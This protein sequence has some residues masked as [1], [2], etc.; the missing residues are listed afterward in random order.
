MRRP[1]FGKTRGGYRLGRVEA[2]P[3]RSLRVLFAVLVLAAVGAA[4]GAQQVTVKL[5]AIN[6]FHGYTEPTETFGLPDPANP[7]KTLRVPV[8]GAAYL[9]A[10][11]AQ[12]RAKNPRS[13]VVGAGDMVGASPLTSAL[14]HDE[15]TIQALNMMGLEY[16]SVGNHEFDEGRAE[17]L[18]KQ[19]GGCR[20][21]GKIGVDTCLI[22]GKFSGA[23]YEYLAANVI[24]ETTGK[25]IFPPYAIKYFSAPGGKRVPIAFVGV[26]LAE[27]PTMVVAAGVKGLKFTDE[28]T[29][30]NALLPE[31][32]K[33][34]VHAVV[35]LI[36][37][38]IFTKVGYNDPSCGGADGDLL[39]ILNKL[40]PSIRLVLSGHTHWPYICPNGQG[41]T[42]PHVFYSSAG[43][44][45]QIV[46]DVDVTLDVAHDTIANVTAQN[47]L[48][49]N[50]Q[51]PNPLASTLPALAPVPA[52][53]A[54]IARYHTKTAPLVN[55]VI[56]HI[57]ADIDGD[58]ADVRKSG[59]GESSI[60]DLV[61]DAR[62]AATQ[63]P[64]ASAQL[65]VINGFG[66]GIRNVLR[67]QALSGEI[68]PGDVT[69]GEAYNVTPF[70]DELYTESLTGAQLIALLDEQWIDKT[71]VELL[72]LSRNVHFTW[73]AALPDGHS[74]LIPGS[75]TVDGLPVNPLATYRVTIDAF[76]GGGGDKYVV[77]EKGTNRTPGVVDIQ[78]LDDYI[79]THSP[80]TPPPHDRI[81]RLH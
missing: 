65:A 5:I 22:D 76:I 9:A 38:G 53:A 74:K 59:S 23:K 47:D 30:V 49:V 34:G 33:R 4:P 35:V 20:P 36:H 27:T 16:T 44:Y 25:T 41:T 15:P 8:G 72:A 70:G 45:G 54:L 60:G 50:D 7:G 18:R 81:T 55:R 12:L 79:T 52:I 73:D 14:F 42:N 69:F 56:G 68:A 37:Q 61:A 71:D 32:N 29:A 39:P 77:L 17:L 10:E 67:Y 78:A 28:A 26:V 21:G 66:A 3:M 57:T 31:L 46:S 2:A 19:Y 63:A 80:L 24:D 64:P 43:R 1:A 13:V 40:D 75:V 58:D 51:A 62:L 48:V 6:D 11:I